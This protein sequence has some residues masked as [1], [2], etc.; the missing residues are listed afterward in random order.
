MT[1][2][3]H[4]AA[5]PRDATL[6]G[7]SGHAPV[8]L[9]VPN[10]RRDVS[11]V[12]PAVP[13]APVALRREPSHMRT[14]AA[15]L[16][17]LTVLPAVPWSAALLTAGAE[18]SGQTAPTAGD[19][20]ATKGQEKK[21]NAD[22]RRRKPKF[23]IGKET[24]Y[25][26][27]PVD[28]NGYIDYPAALNE[29]LSESVTPANNAVVLIWQA[30]GPRPEGIRMPPG[31]FRRLGTKEPPARG[32]YFVDLWRY[33]KNDRKLGSAEF[34]DLIGAEI[35]R[36]TRS[37]WT[38]RQY[39]EM[40][41]WLKANEK[42]LSIAVEASKRPR[43]YF[44]LVPLT[45]DKGTGGL[46]AATLSGV[47]TCRGLTNALAARAMLRVSDGRP[48]DAWQDL[49]ACHRLGRLV[50]QGGSLIEFLFGLALDNVASKADLG[51][52]SASRLSARRL[53]QC[54]LDLRRLP[55]LPSL[56]DKVALGERFMFL[57]TTMGVAR[58]GVK[59]LEALADHGGPAS[60]LQQV[61]TDLFWPMIDWDPALKNGNRWY[62]RLAAALRITDRAK[63]EQELKRFAKEMSNLR[64]ETVRTGGLDKSRLR[65]DAGKALGQAVGNILVLLVFPAPLKATAAAD[66]NAQVRQN[67]QVAF[68]LAAYHRD[69]GRYPASLGD[70]TPAYL[71]KVPPDTFSGK[72]LVYR[73][74]AKGYLLYSVGA[75]GKDE[76][77]R[78]PDDEPA[79]DDIAVRMPPPESRD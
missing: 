38:R 44:P 21:A 53:E 23:T 61:V 27:G 26:T 78:G 66:R 14:I 49:L 9:P 8:R 40:A 30:I 4:P 7:S 6:T 10:V 11:G 33:R 67:L 69:H 62:D 48:E 20:P 5:D 24:T 31:F 74:G 22:T 45:T 39:P 18:P 2:Q 41:A 79:G 43:Y 73:P 50:A 76:Q 70:L 28:K 59:A 64:T 58:G 35:G 63:R 55:P 77:G 42:P 15:V 57:D 65:K 37:P 1:E 60:S 71:A 68:A 3:R 32:E 46:L 75:N 54:R 25:V 56:A 36:C 12:L 72:P 34:E 29:R 52:L 16:L 47:Q 13:P 19:Q 17:M 51:F